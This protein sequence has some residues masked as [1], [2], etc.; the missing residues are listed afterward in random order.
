MKDLLA[1]HRALY[2]AV[3]TGD[4][5]LM[6]SLWV[7]DPS[8]CCIHPNAGALFGTAAVLRSWSMIMANSAYLQFF[9]TEVEVGRPSGGDLA[10]VT[11]Q[12]SV[13]AD[14]SSVDS[15]TGASAQ[16]TA[17]LVRTDSGWRYWSRHAS[18]RVEV[19]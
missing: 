2:D 4:I 9:L 19:T 8:T 1:A 10:V 17:L 15:F 18:A 11:C 7:D 12:E 5:D 13:L 14:G 16:C 6:R 3:E